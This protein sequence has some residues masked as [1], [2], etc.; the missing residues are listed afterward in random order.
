MNLRYATRRDAPSSLNFRWP[1]AARA[2]S[3]GRRASEVLNNVDAHSDSA[4][5][6]SF[7]AVVYVIDPLFK[8]LK[9]FTAT[10]LLFFVFK[11]INQFISTSNAFSA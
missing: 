10:H 6:F 9:Y 1:V 7:V 2:V 3:G 8:S 4:Y 11:I 5:E